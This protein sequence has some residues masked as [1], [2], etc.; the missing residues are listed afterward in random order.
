MV[1][2]TMI[3]EIMNATSHLLGWGT[4]RDMTQGKSGTTFGRSVRWRDK[5]SVLFL[6]RFVLCLS[7]RTINISRTDRLWS[8]KRGKRNR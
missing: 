4:F 3:K 6:R 7:F 2:I 1:F 8:N 5:K